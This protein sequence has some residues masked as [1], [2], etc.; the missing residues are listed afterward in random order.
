[1]SFGKRLV[2]VRKRKNLSQEDVAKHLGTKSPVIGRYER[3]EMKPSIETAT[4]LADFLEVS[5]DFLV[6][7][8]DAEIDTTT[9]NRILEVQKLPKEVKD[10]LFYF[11]DMSVRDYKAK[12]AYS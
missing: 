8:V 11:I 10:K 9:L 5:L 4:K 6:G 2:E 3:D 1:M 7:K 12:K